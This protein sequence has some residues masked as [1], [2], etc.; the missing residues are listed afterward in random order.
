MSEQWV[1]DLGGMPEAR[2]A[3]WG[4]AGEAREDPAPKK[5][6]GRMVAAKVEVRAAEGR[7]TIVGYGAV[8]NVETVIAGFF[9][10]QI[11]PGAFAGLLRSDV[12]SLFN[13]D[14]NYVL[15]RVSAGTLTLSEDATGLLYTVTPPASFPPHIIENLE[16][17]DVTGSSFGFTVKRDEWTRPSTAGE[18]PLRTIW[19][20]EDLL[21]VGPVTFP[22]YEETS[23][24]A[25]NAAAAAAAPRAADKTDVNA[26]ERFRHALEI[27]DTEAL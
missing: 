17:N 14:P 10:E 12:R 9:R 20:V 27:L 5:K 16:R 15:G 1:V 6:E 2:K 21:D 3:V 7:K 24:E 19:E 18:L 23:A 8:F 26:R 4:G 25:R 11:M 22:A 13:H